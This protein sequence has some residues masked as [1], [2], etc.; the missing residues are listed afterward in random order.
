MEGQGTAAV[1]SGLPLTLRNAFARTDTHPLVLD[2]ILAGRYG[3]EWLVWEPETLWATIERD[4]GLKAEI[5]KIVRSGV[6][7]VRTIHDVDAFYT[8]WEVCNWCVQAL[9][10][11]PPDFDVLQDALPGPIMHAVWCAH[12]L[13]GEIPYA[14]EV[15]RWMACSFL[16]Y[17]LVHAPPP[18]EFIQD[19]IAQVEARCEKCGNIEWADGLTECPDC[20]A[21]KDQLHLKP[22]NEW[23]DVR[24]MWGTMKTLDAAQV[25]LRENRLGVQ[26]ARLFVARD[27]VRER[28]DLLNRQLK[29]LGHD[30]VSLPQP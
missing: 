2:R 21:P 24:D 10:G 23:A 3:V 7:A 29:E 17:G 13:R 15:Q 20:G 9:D 1:S 11:T 19:E 30:A 18:V 16:A 22:R 26:M 14:D 12:L 4:L 6:Q 27:Y 25:V 5:A 8:D 28:L